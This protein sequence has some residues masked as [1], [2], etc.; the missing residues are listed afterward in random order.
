M[1]M[2]RPTDVLVTGFVKSP[3][4]L[5]RSLA[6][7][8][9]LKHAGIVRSIHCV[10]W[11]SQELDAHVAPLADLPEV[12]LIRAPPPDVQGSP[13]QRGVTYQIRNLEAALAL[14]PEDDSLI[15]KWRPDFV[16]RHD[17][18]R[19]KIVNFDSNCAVPAGTCLGVAMPPPV[20][21]HKLWIP[22]ADSSQPFFYEDAVF[23]GARR[24]VQKL[25]TPLTAQ[26][27]GILGD[28]LCGSYAHVVRYAKLFQSRYPLFATYLK[29]FRHFPHDVEYRKQFVPYAAD[30]GYFWHLLIAHAWILHSQFH[31]DMGEPGDLL[32]YANAVNRDTDWSDPASP[33]VTSPYDGVQGWRDGAKA[34]MALPSVCRAFG[35]LMDDAWHKALFIQEVPDLPRSS[36][37]ALMENVARCRDGRLNGIESEFYRNVEQIY[38]TYRAT[39][40]AS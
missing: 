32:F 6:P 22:W 28:P 16:A 4:L 12:R 19:D 23:L 1:R 10:T 35:R 27:M 9:R 18:L 21:R 29:A 38:R 36:V 25:V 39:A 40:L 24:D 33:R 5:A 17:F 34:G 37:T 7:L 20:F 31:V 3:H 13:N 8:R 26:D 14:T 30:N 2:T 11:T 15:L